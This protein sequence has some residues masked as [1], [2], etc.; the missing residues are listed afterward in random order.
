MPRF[1]KIAGFAIAA[2]AV[3]IAIRS[4]IIE[5]REAAKLQAE[6]DKL[7]KSISEICTRLE[8]DQANHVT[9]NPWFV[10]ATIP[11]PWEI[12]L[13]L[14]TA[15][16]CGS[17]EPVFD[18]EAALSVLFDMKDADPT[19]DATTEKPASVSASLTTACVL[20]ETTSHE[21]IPPETRSP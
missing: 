3:L 10:A 4:E 8:L 14:K 16:G 21:E 15:R 5:R 6:L 19:S 20:E 12:P 18:F 9:R 17:D 1:S 11:Q 7:M 13:Y 2:F